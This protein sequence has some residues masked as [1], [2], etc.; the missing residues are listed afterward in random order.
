MTSCDRVHEGVEDGKSSASSFSSPESAA[1]D[2]D[3]IYICELS[4]VPVVKLCCAY[5]GSTSY[6]C[7]RCQMS[8][9]PSTT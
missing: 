8:P 1:I 4:P 6:W 3:G 5:E 2:P 7:A 9:I